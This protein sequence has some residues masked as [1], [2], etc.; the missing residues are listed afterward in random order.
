MV[1]VNFPNKEL[2]QVEL[3][4]LLPAL[5]KIEYENFLTKMDRITYLITEKLTGQDAP[6]KYG[7]IT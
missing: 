5:E 7:Q 4:S 3:S 2:K 6:L 1:A